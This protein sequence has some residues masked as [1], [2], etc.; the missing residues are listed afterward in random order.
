MGVPTA[1]I[2]RAAYDPLDTVTI[3]GRSTRSLTR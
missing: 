2:N 3:A 1:P